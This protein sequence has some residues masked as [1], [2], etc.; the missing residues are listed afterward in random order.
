M[1]GPVEPTGPVAALDDQLGLPQDAEVLRDGRPGHIVESGS[2]LGGRKLVGPHQPEDL[3][4]PR[5][6]KGL[7]RC[8]HALKCKL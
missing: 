5:L 8:V 7:E 2:D 4:P 6:S 3:P 1:V